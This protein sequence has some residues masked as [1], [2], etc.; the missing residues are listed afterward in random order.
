MIQNGTQPAT[1]FLK[2]R[3]AADL[4]RMS[5]RGVRAAINDGRLKAHRLGGRGH[6]RISEAN[7]RAALQRAGFL[8]P[9]AEQ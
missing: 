2:V 4:L 8:K 7:L 3:E 5:P 9:E 1:K 6:L